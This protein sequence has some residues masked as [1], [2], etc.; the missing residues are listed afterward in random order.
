MKEG[1]SILGPDITPRLDQSSQE[2]K[3]FPRHI[4]FAT[5]D[6][7]QFVNHWWILDGS[8]K[9]DKVFNSEFQQWLTGVFVSF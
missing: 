7:N 1:A 8:T 4:S 9:I 2:R 6:M 3:F 5:L